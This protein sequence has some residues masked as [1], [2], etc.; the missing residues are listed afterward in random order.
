MP[1]AAN[2]VVWPASF[3]WWIDSV[4][5]FLTFTKPI[6]KIGQIGEE[7]NDIAIM[8]DLS[9]H[10]AEL[11]R[12]DN[13]VLLI[14]HADTTVNGVK[15][16]T[17]LL[18]HGDKIKMRSVEF[19]VHQPIPACST[20]KLTLTSR[21]RMPLALD[22]VILLGETCVLGPRPDAHVR[23]PWQD[24][25]FVNWSKDRFWLR[26]PGTLKIDGKEYRDYGPLEPT[27][28]VIGKW[29]AFRWEPAST[30]KPN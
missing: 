5:G 19:A 20:I 18:K 17:F 7:D 6:V 11:R 30:A 16:N 3:H 21:H 25:L 29:G 13:G 27:S 10:H 8:G 26:G 4:G 22:G 2:K 15:A 12:S 28:N 23:T 9:R 14:A 24:S 1:T